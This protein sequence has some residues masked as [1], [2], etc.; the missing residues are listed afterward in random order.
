MID[1]IEVHWTGEERVSGEG[2]WR[3]TKEFELG[4][5]VGFICV[6]G[7]GVDGDDDGGKVGFNDNDGDW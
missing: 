5:K 3:G 1:E 6:N 7:D 4:G 2:G